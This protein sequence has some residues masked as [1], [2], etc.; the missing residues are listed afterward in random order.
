MAID[1]DIQRM[2]KDD[3]QKELRRLKDTGVKV[4][5]SGSVPDLKQRLQDARKTVA[6]GSAGAAVAASPGSVCVSPSASRFFPH[7][8]CVS[9]PGLLTAPL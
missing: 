2:K 9:V 5:V 3:L 1:A 8:E 4:N 6:T 7:Y